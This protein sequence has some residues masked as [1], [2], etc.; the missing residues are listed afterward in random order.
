TEPSGG[1]SGVI[2]HSPPQPGIASWTQ[3]E[4][5][6]QLSVVHALPSSQLIAL[7]L[8]QV[9]PPHVSPEV[10]ALPSAQDALL[11]VK[12]HPVAASQLSFVHALPSSQL[13]AVPP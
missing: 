8:W 12:T 1:V 2:V 3:P 7:P 11:F 4:A 10:Q 5:G 6:L 13:T 9:P